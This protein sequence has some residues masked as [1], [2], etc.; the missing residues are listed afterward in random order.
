MYSGKEFQNVLN[1]IKP[2][3]HK[4]PV[5]TSSYVNE[6]LGA[7]VFFKCENFQK[8]GAFKMRGAANAIL[9]LT[10]EAKAK[11][12]VTHSS[13]NFAQAVAL[14]AKLMEI[15]AYIV[16]PK[17]APKVKKMAVHDYGGIIIESENTIESRET[18]AAMV[19]EK[20]GATFLHPYNQEEVIYG[21][22]TAALELINEIEDLN[23]L[24]TPVGGGGLI[25]GTALVASSFSPII[26]VYGAEPKIVDDAKRSLMSGQIERNDRTDS[27]AD[28]LRT[29]LG[30]LT[31]PIIRDHV[32][33]ILTVSENEILEAMRVA[34]ERMKIVV[35]PSSAV[36]L[37]AL[38]KYKDLFKGTKI[39]LIV[40]GGNVDLSEFFEGLIE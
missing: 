4:T 16:M 30:S 40:S 19:T 3:I 32:T 25:S 38:I 6:L 1:R 17:N 11:G 18:T 31:F 21:Q 37:A 34:Y 27:I 23:V 29:T 13:G 8:M 36:P 7:E 22:G 9:A 26:K 33:D 10:P 35:E 5:L 39:G 20:Y 14:A 12:V 24:I 15:K 2:F 28:G